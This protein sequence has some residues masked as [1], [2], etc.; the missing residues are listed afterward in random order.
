VRVVELDWRSVAWVLAAFAGLA[1]ATTAVRAAPR[2]VTALAIGTMVALALDPLVVAV[3][4]AARVRRSVAVALVLAG[5]LTAVVGLALLLGPPAVREARN[6]ERD[7]PRVVRQLDD[8]PVVGDDLREARAAKRL[9]TWIEGLPERLAGD[10]TPI[11]RAGQAVVS[12]ALSGALILLVAVTLLLDG[13]RLVAAAR[14]LVRPARRAQA[15]RIGS[16]AYAV[17]GRYVAGSLFVAAVA[18]CA[19]LVAG[20][21]L[22]VPLTPLVA[23][24][25]MVFDL[26]PQIGGA[27][28]G[29]PFVLLGF[30]RSATTGVACAVFFVLYLQVEN[31]LI[32][33]LVVGRTVR[34]SPPATMTAALVGVSAAGV[35]GALVAVPL[36]GAAKVAW[37]ELHPKSTEGSDGVERGV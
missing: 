23:V 6:L 16:L 1:A 30:A 9:Q 5:F 35:V 27:A 15:D 31:H 29:I 37:A 18:F 19:V 2:T 7:L 20:L 36:V 26:V 13:H 28:G 11:V 34:L 3:Q 33:P 24:W 12:G 22:S 4:R 32:Q 21:A 8:L 10:T 17:V 25:V 14:R